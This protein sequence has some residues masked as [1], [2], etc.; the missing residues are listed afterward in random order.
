GVSALR[1]HGVRLPRVRV[2][3]GARALVGRGFQRLRR[4][5]LVLAVHVA[6]DA[7]ADESAERRTADRGD[8]V[9]G[10]V[11]D[12]VADDAAD[13]GSRY[14]A[15]VFLRRVGFACAE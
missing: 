13:D 6:A 1:C 8:R 12:L 7:A 9:T 5:P 11:S 3:P 14:H 10:A 2:A 15:D 4:L